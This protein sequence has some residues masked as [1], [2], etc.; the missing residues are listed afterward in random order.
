MF[1]RQVLFP[2]ISLF[3]F[4]VSLYEPRQGVILITVCCYYKRGRDYIINIY[5]VEVIAFRVAV[6]IGKLLYEPGF[7]GYDRIGYVMVKEG[8]T[9]LVLDNIA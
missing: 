9:I 4:V 1:F 8:W 5:R 6:V 2:V 7:S 3:K